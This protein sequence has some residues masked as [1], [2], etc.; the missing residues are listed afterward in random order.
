M[1]PTRSGSEPVRGRSLFPGG[2]VAVAVGDAVGDGVAV[3]RG[4][5]V[6]VAVGVGVGVT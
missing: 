3:G 2:G 5:G 1:R 4:D 6:D